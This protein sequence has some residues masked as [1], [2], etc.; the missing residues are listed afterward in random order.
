MLRNASKFMKIVIDTSVLGLAQLYETART[1][2]YRTIS[3][4]SQELLT[5]SELELCY[6]SRSSLQVNMLTD[7][8]FH[9]RGLGDR[10]F[11]KNGAERLLAA[12]AGTPK[13]TENDSVVAKIFSRLYRCS[14]TYRMGG[15]ADIFHSMYSALPR[16]RFAPRPIRMMT[17]YDI[18]PLLHPEY[19]AD[20]FVEQFRPI[21]ESFSPQHDFVITISE[22]TKNDICSYFNMD[23]RRVFVT[24]LAA[25]PQLYHPISDSRLINAVKQ[26][27][28]IPRGR[29]FLTLA[30]V[31]KRKNLATSIESFRKFSTNP[32]VP[33]SLSF[34]WARAAGRFRTL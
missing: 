10:A 6:C 34:W 13:T 1:G 23:P 32:A 29:Y 24:P 4:L 8:Y 14:Q 9:E 16:F 25:S 12:L 3:S 18:I 27:F 33:T 20:G 22:S 21:V 30:T 19:F 5:R 11:P 26:Q 15:T 31:E 28:A 17:I 2:I 7:A